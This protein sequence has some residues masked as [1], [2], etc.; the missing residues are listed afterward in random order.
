MPSDATVNDVILQ[1]FLL[2]RDFAESQRQLVILLSEHAEARMRGIIMSRLCSY[3]SSQEHIAESEDVYSEAKT[4]LLT[5]LCD[6]KA[7]KRNTPCEDF[8]GYVATIAH[9]TCHD[10]F[11]QAHPARSRLQKKIRDLLNAHSNFGMWKSQDQKKGEWL[12]GFHGWQ[13]RRSSS[14]STAWLQRFYERPATVTEILAPGDDIQWMEIHDLLAAIFTDV[15][16]PISLN[17]LINV[18]SDIKGVKDA[19]VACLDGNGAT[20]SLRLMD[21]RLRVDSVLEIREPLTRVWKGLCELP[22]DQFKAYLLHA[23]DSSEEPLISLF[24]D[25]EITT[26]SEIAGLLE[27]TIDQFR[28]LC[29]NR[30]PMDISTVSRELGVKVE[31]V[32]KLR[33]QAGKRLKKLLSA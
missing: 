4:R 9:N 33:C 5:Y 13:G 17:H 15:G 29:V 16:E 31:R 11:R 7:G 25:A 14:I 1:P 8:T 20:L 18:V 23:Q 32:Y 24:L 30:L 19:P 12:C 2:A 3:P 21:S 6:L 27:M 26:E 28:D 10:H 22:R